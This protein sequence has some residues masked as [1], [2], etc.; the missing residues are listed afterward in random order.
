MHKI[1]QSYK[2]NSDIVTHTILQRSTYLSNKYEANIY[3]KR[4]DMQ[5]VRSF[6]IRGAAEAIKALTAEERT[7]GVV[8][9]S[10]GNHAQGVAY[11]CNKLKIKGTI[12]MPEK[13]PFIKLNS[14]KHFGKEYVDV[15]LV[16]NTFDEAL[17]Q[18]VI[19]QEK[20]GSVFVHAFNN[21][22]VIIGQG[23]M[24]CEILEDWKDEASIDYVFVCVG[25]GGLISGVA[26]YFKGLS[27]ETEVIGF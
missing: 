10:A 6:K 12:F 9:A 19:F 2:R 27:P 14:V 23:G 4:E 21:Y 11:C 22:N 16:G 3:I 7:K 26:S 17:A 20:T 1:F 13:T 15:V 25:G 18:A 24:A 5:I 8:T